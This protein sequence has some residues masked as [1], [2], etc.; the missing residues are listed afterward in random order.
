[1]TQHHHSTCGY[2]LAVHLVCRGGTDLVLLLLPLTGA[3]S[4]S[5]CHKM[6]TA[7]VGQRVLCRFSQAHLNILISRGEEVTQDLQKDSTHQQNSKIVKDG[8]YQEHWHTNIIT[9]RPGKEMNN[10]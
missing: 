5:F 2:L 8:N 7:Q 3:L 1:M 9:S 10:Q 6:F 4:L